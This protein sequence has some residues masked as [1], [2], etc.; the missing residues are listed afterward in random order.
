MKAIKFIGEIGSV[1]AKKDGS[2]GMR[3]NTPELKTEQKA[4][5]MDLQ[6]INVDVFI[7]PLDIAPSGLVQIDKDIN[8]K[9]QSQILRSVLFL[10]WRQDGEPDDFNIY[11]HKIYNKIIDHFKSKIE[12]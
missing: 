9:S 4:A 11:Y 3:L 7:R 12:E 10:L 6:A 5:I 1:S 2:V 8:S